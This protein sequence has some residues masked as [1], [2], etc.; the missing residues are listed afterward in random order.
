MADFGGWSA[1]GLAR[2]LGWLG[3]QIVSEVPPELAA[4]EFACRNRRCRY[5]DWVLCE[6]RSRGSARARE[7]RVPSEN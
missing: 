6:T 4:C 5:D 3:R 1:G 7:E 2:F